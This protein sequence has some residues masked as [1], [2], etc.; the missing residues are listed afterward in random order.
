MDQYYA[1]I[2]WNAGGWSI[3]SGNKAKLERNSFVAE[4]G[5]G[6]EEWLFNYM[7]PFKGYN[8][9]FLQP[10]HKSFQRI[11]GKSLDIL[12]WAIDP[13]KHH[14]Q[15]GEI[16]KCH[17]LTDSE[18]QEA[19]EYYK[20]QGRLKQME[21]DIVRVGANKGVMTG[22]PGLFNIR[23]RS[24]DAVQ[25]DDPLPSAN[26]SDI[27]AKLKSYT[28]VH[29]SQSQVDK[30]WY[31]RTRQ[32]TTSI[33]I[34]KAYIRPSSQGGTVDPYHPVLQGELMKLLQTQFGKDKVDRE[35][36]W[37][38]ITVSIGTKKMLIE[39]KT[40]AVA[41]RAI[42]EALGQI[43]EYAYFSSESQGQK[44]TE[45]T[46]LFIVA[47]GNADEEV[48]AYLS[49]LRNKFHIPIR[50]CSFSPGSELP[51]AFRRK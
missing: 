35:S 8:Y 37:I 29:A 17:V 39:I 23:F 16:K 24:G 13:D 50:Y 48:S 2:C 27:I 49:L 41:K 18:A 21:E 26:P 51:K 19:Y 1:R 4:N 5:F 22:D 28:L 7:W 31:A 33:P 12:L 20:K 9:A 30:Q 10:V 36:R 15:V 34:P 6:Y 46:E 43:L 42:R 40:D 45:E 44:Q 3:P 11:K 32:G 14:V 38:D 47:P 25:Y